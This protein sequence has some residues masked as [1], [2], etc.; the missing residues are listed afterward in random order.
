MKIIA[1][2]DSLTV[3]LQS[4][5]Q[6]SYSNEWIPYPR[7]LEHLAQEYLKSLGSDEKLQVVNKGISGDLTQ[8]M[9]ERFDRD[10][11]EQQP[12][13]VIIM[14]GANDIGWNLESSRIFLN[15][16]ATYD[17][18]ARRGIEP[19]A[20]TVPSILGFDEL[21]PPRLSLST[22]IREEA[23]KRKM[24]FVD[25]FTATADPTT[26]ELSQRYSGD[27]LHLNAQG[28]QRI[29]ETIFKEWLRR[30]LDQYAK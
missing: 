19:V 5:F 7:Y 16:K 28:Y 3:G 24:A 10:V 12:S 29:G 14:G 6:L 18:A 21:I 15:L 11:V 30:V 17:R 1:F 22:M 9:L 25:V 27:G 23:E 8:D 26:G 4:Q 13:Y 20:C 2:G